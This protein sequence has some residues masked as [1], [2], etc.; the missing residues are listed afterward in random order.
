VKTVVGHGPHEKF[1]HASF[2]LRGHDD[3]DHVSVARALTDDFAYRCGI[4]LVGDDLRGVLVSSALDFR[5]DL[6]GEVPLG[7]GA[8]RRFLF[9]GIGF[10]AREVQVGFEKRK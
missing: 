3:R 2:A 4:R 6:S 10:V 8:P 1:P 5:V 7:V 9:F